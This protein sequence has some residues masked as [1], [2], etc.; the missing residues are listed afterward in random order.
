YFGGSLN[1]DLM[2]RG[3]DTRGFDLPPYRSTVKVDNVR[4]QGRDITTDT[5]GKLLIMGATSYDNSPSDFVLARFTKDGVLD[6]SFNASGANSGKAG[7]LITDSPY[8]GL[9]YD[10]KVTP[11]GEIFILAEIKNKLGVNQRAIISF[12]KDGN[13]NSLFGNPMS[14]Q[15]QKNTDLV[16]NVVDFGFND[17]DG[18][19]FEAVIIDKLPKT[20][21][22][23][24]NG[25][26][27]SLNQKIKASEI[28]TGKLIFRP[29]TDTSGKDYA[30]F[31]YRVQDDGGTDNGGNDISN[32]AT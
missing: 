26:A 7:V 23:L 24:L 9:G 5:D 31:T 19:N 15:A 29:T 8:K 6:T 10:L 12:D 14:L 32:P 11:T 2:I 22:L 21:V 20:G 17:S 25:A 28:E 4:L 1:F 16:L 18:D 27:V 13:T 3:F 30:N